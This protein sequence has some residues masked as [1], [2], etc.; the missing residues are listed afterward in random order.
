MYG[1]PAVLSLLSLSQKGILRLHEGLYLIASQ[2]GKK[3][4][5]AGVRNLIRSLLLK[6]QPDSGPNGVIATQIREIG[7]SI[8]TDELM[9]VLKSGKY[10]TSS[11]SGSRVSIDIKIEPSSAEVTLTHNSSFI[12]F[13]SLKY[14]CSD[15][16]RTKPKE[17]CFLCCENLTVNSKNYTLVPAV[18]PIYYDGEIVRY[19]YGFLLRD[20]KRDTFYVISPN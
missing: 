10:G 20:V 13:K 3:T 2:L 18:I 5:S 6:Q 8:E 17:F 14:G 7:G 1:D 9:S 11:D 16:Q 15:E 4:N 19:K 12:P